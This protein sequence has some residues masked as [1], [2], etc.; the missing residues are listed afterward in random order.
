MINI[1][2]S[3]RDRKKIFQHQDQICRWIT[4][5]ERSCQRQPFT[6]NVSWKTT[7]ERIINLAFGASI[8]SCSPEDKEQLCALQQRNDHYLLLQDQYGKVI[9]KLEYWEFGNCA[10]MNAWTYLCQWEQ[11]LQIKSQTISVH[12]RKIMEPCKNC[13]AIRNWLTR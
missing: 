4:I 5:M 2:F 13:K 7:R 6:V 9:P 10:E 11:D 8:T 1:C 12:R 3:K